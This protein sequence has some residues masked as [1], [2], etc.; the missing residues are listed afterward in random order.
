[1]EKEATRERSKKGARV[2]IAAGIP[3]ELRSRVAGLLKAKDRQGRKKKMKKRMK[4]KGKQCVTKKH[5]LV[6]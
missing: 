3:M 1:M 4:K 2:H 6:P 5:H